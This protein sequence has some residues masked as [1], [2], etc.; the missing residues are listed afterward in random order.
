MINK[1]KIKFY[2]NLLWVSI[3]GLI[4]LLLVIF[5]ENNILE[6]LYF[7]SMI[8]TVICL[9]IFSWGMVYHKFKN[10]RYLWLFIDLILLILGIFG[11]IFGVQISSMIFYFTFMRKRF[12]KG[13]GIYK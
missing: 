12:K 10:K 13:K 9:A 11:V 3:P 5:I 1:S 7:A 2:D 4:L 6:A 8:F